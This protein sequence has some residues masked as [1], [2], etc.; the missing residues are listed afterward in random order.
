[1][2]KRSRSASRFALRRGHKMCD[3]LLR[4]MAVAIAGSL[5]FVSAAHAQFWPQWA[6]NPQHTSQ[7]NVAGQ[8]LNNI[9]TSIVYD[10]LVP[11]EMAANA[12][13]LLAHYQVPLVDG[14]R[15]F[16]EFKSGT[17]NKNTYSTEVWGENGFQWQKGQLTQVWSFTSDWTAPGSQA[18]FW[19]PVFHGALA[20][21]SVYVPGAGG[22]LLKL[23]EA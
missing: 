18:D 23:D 3:S 22:T 15:V 4:K 13:N 17:Y 16:M 8:P 19:E 1:M 7:V 11:Q 20:N 9:L 2:A 10:P 21:N 14:N 12:G 5:A 6:L